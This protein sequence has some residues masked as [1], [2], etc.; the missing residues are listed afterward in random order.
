MPRKT[1]RYS[2]DATPSRRPIMS[3][4]MMARSR[5]RES[6]LRTAPLRLPSD[7]DAS[8]RSLGAEELARLRAVIESGILTATK[9]RQTPRARG[10][11]GQLDR[12]RARG[13]VQLGHRGGARRDRRDRSRA[14]RRDRHHA[15]HRHGRARPILYQGAIPVFAD[16]D[17]RTGMVTAESI[18]AVISRPD[19]G[20]RRH[21]SVRN[22]GDGRRDHGAPSTSRIPVVEDCAQAFLT[23]AR[24]RLVG[25]VRRDGLFLHPAG[26]AHH[27]RRGRARG[28]GLTDAFA[29]RARVFVNKAWP[30]G[31]ANPDHEFLALNYRTTELQSAV[32]N[33]QLEKLAA[34]VAQR[35]ADGGAVRGEDRGSPRRRPLAGGDGRRRDLVEGAAPRGRRSIP[36]GPPAIAAA[37]G[38]LGVASAPRYIQK[39]AFECRVFS[40]QRTFGTSRWPFTLARPEAVDYSTDAFSGDLRVP[41]LRARAPVER[42]VRGRARRRGGRCV[43]RAWSASWGWRHDR[44][45]RD[46]RRRGHRP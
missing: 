26:Q 13:R 40:E 18:A 37:L 15:D 38:E 6:D 36:G 4:A 16:V 14:R 33:A 24:G 3:R 12:R 34:G 45:L 31:E 29:R 27:H 25:H 20:G 46:R 21:A 8:G 2:T 17:P 39:P 19:A 9:G 23:R 1:R 5:D 30:Y 10:Q 41:G 28:H 43:D 11:G 7:Q 32:A 35:Q 22:A 44:P 42:A